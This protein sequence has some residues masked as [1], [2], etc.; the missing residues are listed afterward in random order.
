MKI[1]FEAIAENV[2]RA[3]GAPR[4]EPALFHPE[5]CC[6]SCGYGCDDYY[7]DDES[8]MPDNQFQFCP[9]C[10]RAVTDEAMN[11][12]MERLRELKKWTT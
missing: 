4:K 5:F 8:Q 7:S 6:P 2:W 1:E 9:C 12:V 3:K 10:G 11:I